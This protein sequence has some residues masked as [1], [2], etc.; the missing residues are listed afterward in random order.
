M[1]KKIKQNKIDLSA[2]NINRFKSHFI[3]IYNEDGKE[4]NPIPDD[5]R[6]TV[7]CDGGKMEHQGFAVNVTGKTI[8]LNVLIADSWIYQTELK[9]LIIANR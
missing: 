6:V 2:G 5:K 8:G 9:K 1:K 7:W 3:K 4:V